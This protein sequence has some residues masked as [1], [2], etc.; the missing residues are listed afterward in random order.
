MSQA[1][2]RDQPEHSLPLQTER[3]TSRDARQEKSADTCRHDS[4]QRA[5]HAGDR[6]LVPRRD[7]YQEPGARMARYRGTR[8]PSR[9]YLGEGAPVCLALELQEARQVRQRAPQPC[10]A[11]G[12]RAPAVHQAVLAN[13]QARS[14]R[15]PR[16]EHRRDLMPPPAGAPD[17]VRP[18]RR[19]RSSAAGQHEGGHDFHGRPQHGPWPAGHARSAGQRRPRSCS[20]RPLWTTF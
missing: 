19:Q 2:R 5:H 18:P 7:D 6:R 4:A 20:S 9:R 13:G 16:R 8:S 15:R 12:Q 17:R 11:R 10:S 3:A 1:V 14:Q